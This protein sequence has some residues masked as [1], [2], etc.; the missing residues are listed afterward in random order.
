MIAEAGGLPEKWRAFPPVWGYLFWGEFGVSTV[1][2][3][4]EFVVGVIWIRICGAFGWGGAGVGAGAVVPV[5]R[6]RPK[7]VT[8]VY[9][10]ACQ[11]GQMQYGPPGTFVGGDELLCGSAKRPARRQIVVDGILM[12]NTVVVLCAGPVRQVH[13]G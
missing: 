3:G 7:A 1:R 8:L 9:S 5:G 4:W 13:F 11:L 6:V 2:L 12:V 10:C